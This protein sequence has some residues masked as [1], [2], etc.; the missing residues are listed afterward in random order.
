LQLLSD[1]AAVGT[2]W[3]LRN[4]PRRHAFRYRAWFSLLDVDALEQ[5]FAQSR[6]WSIE[7]ANLVSFRRSDYIA[8][9]SQPLGE[10]VRQKVQEVL[11]FQPSGRV[12]MLSHL[13]QW[14]VCFNPVS[15]YFCFGPDGQTLQ[16]VVAEVHNTPWGERHAYVLDARDQSGPAY[17]WRFAKDFH[18]SP[19][20]PMALEYDW[21]FKL[22]PGQVEVHMKVMD[23]DQECFGAG[24]RLDLF[25]LSPASMRRMPLSYPWMT[26]R[27]LAGIYW[28][29]LRLWLKRTPFHE[30]P[31]RGRTENEIET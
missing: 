12:W 15:L 5:R 7:R 8:P 6:W 2:I 19:F 22:G 28:Q 26:A 1:S 29:A 3:H 30:H 20:L 17:R 24:M 18:V 4:R 11:G 23:G 13:R 9:H 25:P 14:G 16:A 10:A 27:V 21:Q 31:G